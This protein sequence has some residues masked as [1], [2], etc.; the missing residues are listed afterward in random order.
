MDRIILRKYF[1]VNH[2]SAH[3]STPMWTI[4]V[5]K[6]NRMAYISLCGRNSNKLRVSTDMCLHKKLMI[7]STRSLIIFASVCVCPSVCVCKIYSPQFY[8]CLQLRVMAVCVTCVVGGYRQ[9]V[10]SQ[11][12]AATQ[13]NELEKA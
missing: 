3:T 9:T 4:Y 10:S 1:L 13:T 5:A 11:T 6:V 7:C 12:E 8:F 2:F